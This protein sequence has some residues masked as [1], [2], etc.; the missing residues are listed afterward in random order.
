M[1]GPCPLPRGH[2]GSI[3]AIDAGMSTP[4][5]SAD[6]VMRAGEWL[7]ATDTT[8]EAPTTF[9][10]IPVR[11]RHDLAALLAKVRAE[12]IEECAR[13]VPNAESAETSDIQSAIRRLASASREGQK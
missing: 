12:T 7:A 1:T 2:R 4:D 13:E 6:L 8:P 9:Y 10:R 5:G 3:E 11:A